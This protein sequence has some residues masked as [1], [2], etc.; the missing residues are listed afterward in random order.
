MPSRVPLFSVTPSLY[1]SLV[2]RTSVASGMFTGLCVLHVSHA[3][4][5]THPPLLFTHIYQQFQFSASFYP[6]PCP[7][8][9]APLPMVCTQ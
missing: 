9:P 4:L 2:H 5:T 3:A 6:F 8:S 1:T 7:G